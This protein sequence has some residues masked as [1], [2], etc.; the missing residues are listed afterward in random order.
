MM[1]SAKIAMRST[2]PPENMLNM[3]SMP[4]AWRLEGL[5]K[6]FRIDAGQRDVGAE[7]VDEQ[8]AQREPDALLELLGLGES[9][10]NSDWRQ[11][12]Q[13]QMPWKFSAITV[14]QA[15]YAPAMPCMEPRPVSTMPRIAM[16]HVRSRQMPEAR[17]PASI[18]AGIGL[19]AGRRSCRLIRQRLQPWREQL[20]RA[21]GLFDLLD[22]SLGGAE[23]RRRSPW[24]SARHPKAGE[25]RPWRGGSRRQP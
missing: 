4:P 20:D 14:G 13:L 22:R 23:R 16:A 18:I 9:V 15:G 2:A 21:A 17:S 24:P 5:G 1:P 11:V 6:G 25:R 10:R 19:A 7:A 12:V 3:P 8:R